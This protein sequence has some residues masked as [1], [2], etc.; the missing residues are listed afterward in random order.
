MAWRRAE[1]RIRD[2]IVDP[3]QFEEALRLLQAIIAV[4]MELFHQIDWRHSRLVAMIRAQTGFDL[5]V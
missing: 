3:D 2:G 4:G 5:A 1:W